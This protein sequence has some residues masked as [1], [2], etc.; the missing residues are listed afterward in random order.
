MKIKKIKK[1]I[2]SC[3]LLS[4]LFCMS[5]SSNLTETSSLD[6]NDTI[7][8]AIDEEN[9]ENIEGF[10][11]YFIEQYPTKK[12]EY[13][14]YDDSII[15]YKLN[16]NRLNCDVVVSTN[17]SMFNQHK[18][19]FVD[20]TKT[21]SLN[22]F[23]A[24]AIE[25]LKASDDKNYCLPGLGSFY[26][27][28]FNSTLMNEYNLTY[29][30][31]LSSLID[32]SSFSNDDIIPF[33]SGFPSDLMYL[34]VFLQ[35]SVGSFFMTTKGYSYFRECQKGN[36]DI[37]NDSNEKLNAALE[38]YSSL[39]SQGY[40]NNQYHD[41]DKSKDKFF[42]GEALCYSISPNLDFDEEYISHDSSFDF[43]FYPFFGTRENENY[44]ASSTDFYLGITIEG[45]KSKNETITDF[46]KLYSS[47]EGQNRLENKKT[48]SVQRK[49]LSY[50]NKAQLKLDEEYSRFNDCIKQGRVFIVDD[51]KETFESS[52]DSIV[53]LGNGDISTTVFLEEFKNNVNKFLNFKDSGYIIDNLTSVD[54]D[55]LKQREVSLSYI[56]SCIKTKKECDVLILP[57]SF[58]KNVIYDNIVFEEE[59]NTIFD[60][61][62]N[63]ILTNLT[64]KEIKNIINNL[65]NNNKEDN[66][67]I[68]GISIN[69]NGYILNDE[70]S[71][72]IF[73]PSDFS[74]LD[75]CK[76]N[77]ITATYNLLNLYTKCDQLRK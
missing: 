17:L 11:S 2:S 14:V 34:D 50:L 16:H 1:S 52:Y 76:I 25:F 35:A 54:E 13:I 15:D 45:R 18:E 19:H 30:T 28:V 20:L 64:G 21:E 41:F 71:Y 61:T 65:S 6:D 75:E 27:Y 66:Y 49:K 8:I 5:C 73:L 58:Q 51:F 47:I 57:Y 53:S 12:V 22:N 60:K 26:S 59:I 46:V 36:F 55:L 39:L 23:N 67:L 48:K 68:Y 44:V 32:F 70:S 40:L 38:I 7:T 31:T 29:P 9:K 42:N 69:D 10:I 63:I 56:A 43:E 77:T 72:S 37:D 33:V 62:L 74:T 4:L 3:F 24:Y